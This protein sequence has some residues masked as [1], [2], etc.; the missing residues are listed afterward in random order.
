MAAT[1]SVHAEIP[2]AVPD[3]ESTTELAPCGRPAR[4]MVDPKVRR[5]GSGPY[6]VCDQH[7]QDSGY[8]IPIPR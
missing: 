4:L 6:Y 3:G 7:A 8:L 1:C 5:P 2:L